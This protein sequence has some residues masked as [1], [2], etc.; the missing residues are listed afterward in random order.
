MT[1]ISI[2]IPTKNAGP[3]F[4]TTLARLRSQESD[5]ETELV[6]IDSGSTDS[7]V[8][9]AERLGANVLHV[10]PSS[11]N[12]GETRNRAIQEASGEIIVLTVQ[13]AVA[14]DTQWLRRLTEW[15]SSDA[16]VAGS[17]GIQV[18][19]PDAD[20]LATWEVE[21]HN[22]IFNK[23]T[24]VKSLSS[25]D[26]FLRRDFMGRFD[27]ALFDNVS[28]AI[29]KSV[30]QQIPFRPAEFA[31]DMEWALEVMR[32]GYRIVHEPKAAVIH[33]HT[34]PALYRL[35]RHF[36]TT[37]RVMQVLESEA[38]DYSRYTDVTLFNDMLAFAIQVEELI[39]RAQDSSPGMTVEVPPLE[40]RPLNAVT[41]AID[42]EGPGIAAVLKKLFGRLTSGRVVVPPGVPASEDPLRGSFNFTMKELLRRYPSLKQ[43]E[44]QFLF[45]NVAAR[46]AGDVLSKYYYWC[47]KNQKLSES[48]RMLGASL[49]QGI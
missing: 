44:L 25:W 36:V 18:A 43:E 37:K 2:V 9:L 17:F 27:L 24:R 11:F 6:I 10:Q 5:A 16:Q 33:S 19:R 40:F 48:M 42:K 14:A 38:E 30:W 20:L 28:S 7:T 29:R 4:E 13:D 49:S 39:Q 8:P 45:L 35:K 41:P 26:D 3:E 22:K 1:R 15:F 32:A 31:E 34:R 21:T 47:N 46:A 12:H 23:G